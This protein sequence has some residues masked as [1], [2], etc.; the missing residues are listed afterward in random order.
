LRYVG[1]PW[2]TQRKLAGKGRFVDFEPLVINFDRATS[3]YTV[4]GSSKA[5][6][7]E[8]DWQ[9]IVST[10]ALTDEPQAIQ[11]IAIRAGLVGVDGKP[12]GSH[13]ARV[14]RALAGRSEIESQSAR[15]GRTGTTYRLLPRR[16]A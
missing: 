5:N 10:G 9:R 1:G 2:D 3:D 8:A 4:V 7:A 13:R 14:K 11:R 6:M 15:D 16:L 12:T